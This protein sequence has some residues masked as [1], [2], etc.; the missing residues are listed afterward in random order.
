MNTPQRRRTSQRRP[1]RPA[2]KPI[3]IWRPVPPLPDPKPIVATADPVAL[4]R[5]LGDPPLGG[6]SVV[7]GH[8]VASVIERAAMMATA[9]AASADLLGSADEEA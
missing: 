8:Y 9:L 7:A 1:N 4:L 3:D 5:S 6:K 2:D